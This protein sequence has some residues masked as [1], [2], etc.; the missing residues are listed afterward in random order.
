MNADQG[1]RLKKN[2]RVRWHDGALGTV[3]ESSYAAVKIEWDDG[4]WALFTF[5]ERTPWQLLEADK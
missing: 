1:K 4:Q 2:D 5:D 3:R